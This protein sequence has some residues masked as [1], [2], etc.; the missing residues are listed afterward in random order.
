MDRD[1]FHHKKIY[2]LAYLDLHM[3]RHHIPKMSGVKTPNPVKTK[4]SKHVGSKIESQT[5]KQFCGFCDGGYFEVIIN[6][7]HTAV[8]LDDSTTLRL[9]CNMAEFDCKTYH[10]FATRRNVHDVC[11]H[12]IVSPT[13][14]GLRSLLLKI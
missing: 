12:S 11:I 6:L 5:N 4:N 2:L 14:F 8:H 3:V 1:G 9:L 7:D 10:A 13:L